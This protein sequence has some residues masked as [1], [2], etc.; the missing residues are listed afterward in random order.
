MDV[1]TFSHILGNTRLILPE[2]ESDDDGERH[3]PRGT[4]TKMDLVSVL[5]E[6][7]V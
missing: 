2:A 7:R 3:G 6:L 5:L 4:S 1:A